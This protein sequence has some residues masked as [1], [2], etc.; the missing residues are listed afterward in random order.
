MKFRYVIEGIGY[1]S[2]TEI[3]KTIEKPEL[4]KWKDETPDADAISRDRATIGTII[5]WRIERLL[6]EKHNLPLVPLKLDDVSIINH[7]CAKEGC[8]YCERKRKMTHA[9]EMIMSYFDDFLTKHTLEPI[10]LEHM[11]CE[12]TFGYAGT[13]DFYGHVDGESSI[14]DFKTAKMFY[15]GNTF[16]AQLAAYKKALKKKVD[17]L[18]ILRLNEETG[19]EL[20]EVSDDWETFKKALDGFREH[21]PDRQAQKI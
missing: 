6:A 9:I 8:Y 21:F 17:R 1:P 2:V 12:K 20:R 19:D 10:L 14:L 16:G 4:K 3:L 5:H 11:V 15:N 18:Y 7:R 13:L